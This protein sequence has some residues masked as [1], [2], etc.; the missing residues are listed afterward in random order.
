ME[1]QLQV[2]TF[3]TIIAIASI[4]SAMATVPYVWRVRCLNLLVLVPHPGRVQRNSQRSPTSYVR[5]VGGTRSQRVL[6]ETKLP[7]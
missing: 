3:L 6:E 2:T 5:L 7:I 1:L 4:G